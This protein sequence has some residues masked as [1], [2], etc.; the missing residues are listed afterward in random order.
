M[1][2]GSSATGIQRLIFSPFPPLLRRGW[3][4]PCDPKIRSERLQGRRISR[5]SKRQA[6]CPLW[7][8]C[9]FCSSFPSPPRESSSFYSLSLQALNGV[10]G[11]LT[12]CVVLGGLHSRLH[13]LCGGSLAD[14]WAPCRPSQQGPAFAGVPHM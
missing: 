3:D 9:P 2:P 13:L 7:L 1:G 5:H 8:W 14:A 6:P 12:Y 11:T 4:C 10:C